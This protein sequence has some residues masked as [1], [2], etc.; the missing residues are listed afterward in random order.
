MIQFLFATSLFLSA[1][2]LFVIQPMVAKA[3]LPLYGGTPAVWSVCMLF[4]QALLL[5]A[6]GYAWLLSRFA[7]WRFGRS[8]HFVVALLSLIVLLRPFI[9][10]ESGAVPEFSIL[11][12]LIGQLGLPLLI[13]GASA[14]LLQFAYSQTRDKYANDP[15]FLYV[16][17]NVGSLLALISYPWLIE[18]TLGIE[19]QFHYW[20]CMFVVYLLFLGIIFF[21]I[22]Y[23]QLESIKKKNNLAWQSIFRWVSYS[24]VPCSL[25]LGVTFYISTDIAATPLLWVFPLALYL[26]SFVITFARKPLIPHAWVERYTLLAVIFP[27]L[28]FIVGASLLQAWQLIIFHLVS[29]FMFALLCHGELV[30]MRPPASQ[31]TSFYFCLALGGVLAGLF[32]GLLAPR[33]FNDAYEYPLIFLLALFCLPLSKSTRL[34]WMPF[35]VLVLLMLNYCLPNQPWVL[36]LKKYHLAEIL[37]L[38]CIIIWPKN[39]IT[40]FVGMSILFVFLF[41]P[42]FKPTKILSQQRNFYGVKQIVSQFGAHVLMSQN[43]VHGFQ[44]E[45]AQGPGNG[46]MAYYGP[47]LPVVR[48]LQETYQPLRATILGLGTGM[49]ACQFHKEDQVDIIDIDEQVLEIAKNSLFFTYLR[50]CPPRVSLVEGDGRLILQSKDKL[51]ELLVVD[52]FSSDAIPTHLLTLEAFKLYQQKI[53]ADGVILVNISN[54]HLNLLPVLTAAGRE[55][56]LLVLHKGHAGNN[57]LGQFQSEWVLLTANQPLSIYLMRSHGWRFVAKR[58]SQL[59]TDDYSNLIPLLKW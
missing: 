41:S 55:L 22:P 15:Y 27:V 32:N 45:G 29:F 31:L 58:E 13:I 43:T 39:R 57:K 28:V 18:Y 11:K 23:Q 47:M 8:L 24:F 50:D 20:Q 51:A 34:G 17:S 46:A 12:D 44:L 53:I 37:A 56:E 36:W 9:P 49:M 33:I 59:W 38:A 26:L 1:A 3:M 2:L 10:S 35:I 42:W 30:R 7:N 25:M 21:A 6:Y 5:S 48:H 52:A 54:R 40:L 4:F 14:P 16:A 19:Q